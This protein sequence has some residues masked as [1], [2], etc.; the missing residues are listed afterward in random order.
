MADIDVFV[1][2]AHADRERVLVL[3]DA[4]AAQGLA[5][6]LDESEIETFTSISAALSAASAAAKLSSRSIR[7]RT[8]H[9]AHVSGSSPRPFSPRSGRVVILATG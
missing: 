6:W 7:G 9:G 8:R 4:L 3:R 1:S 5:V 2:Y